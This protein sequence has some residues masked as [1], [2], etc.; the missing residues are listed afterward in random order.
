MTALRPIA[1]GELLL[2]A[3]AAFGIA[4]RGA[5]RPILGRF[6]ERRLTLT[7]AEPLMGRQ[8]TSRYQR[9]KA[10]SG[11]MIGRVTNKTPQNFSTFTEAGHDNA[12][13]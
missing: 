11:Q 5:E 12:A 6:A 13:P 4:N 1:E 3:M 10:Q 7:S 2:P 8:R 9:A